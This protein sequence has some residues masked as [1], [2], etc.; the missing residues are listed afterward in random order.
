[1][2]GNYARVVIEADSKGRL[3]ISAEDADGYG[4]GFRLAGPKYVGDCVPGASEART[5][6]RHE[7][8]AED[9]AEIRRY[10]AIWDEIQDRT[11][12]TDRMRAEAERVASDPDDLA[13]IRAI[14]ADLGVGEQFLPGQSNT[15]GRE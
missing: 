3:S 15:P 6:V 8:S 13:E 5:V 10:L 12:R 7:L 1:M 11:A 14:R 9:V 4:G 2:S